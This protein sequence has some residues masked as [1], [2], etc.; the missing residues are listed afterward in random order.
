MCLDIGW[1]LWWDSCKLHSNKILRLFKRITNIQF[2]EQYSVNITPFVEHKNQLYECIAYYPHIFIAFNKSLSLMHNT[3][4][5][6]QQ[7]WTMKSLLNNPFSCCVACE[8][9]FTIAYIIIFK[10][11]LA[12]LLYKMWLVLSYA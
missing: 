5:I 4:C 1:V 10:M 9:K 8:I 12:L 2:F 6:A 11:F 7:L 3:Y